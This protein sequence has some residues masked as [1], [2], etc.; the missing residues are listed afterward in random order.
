TAGGSG[1]VTGRYTL[2]TRLLSRARVR[3][4][5]AAASGPVGKHKISE[6]TLSEF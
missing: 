6:S 1:G 3:A 2:P 4:T 5:E